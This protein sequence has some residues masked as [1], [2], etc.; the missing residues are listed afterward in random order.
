MPTMIGIDLGCGKHKAAG[1]IGFDIDPQADPD[2]LCD[3]DAGAL[4]V[5]S[6]AVDRIRCQDIIEHVVDPVAFFTELVRVSSRI[7]AEIYIRTPHFTSRY[8]YNDPTH[9]HQ[10]GTEVVDFLIARVAPRF[11]GCCLSSTGR[12]LFPR[13]FRVLGIAWLMNRMPHR[14]EQL[15]CYLCPAENMEFTIAVR[16]DAES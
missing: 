15:F 13:L 16:W 6:H 11:P 14:Y 1:F 3:F 4:P 2:V 5:R 7:G 9:R 12:L 8:A 10:F